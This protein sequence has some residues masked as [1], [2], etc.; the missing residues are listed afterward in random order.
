MT[1]NIGKAKKID[2]IFVF[3]KSYVTFVAS[4][5]NMKNTFFYYNTYYYFLSQGAGSL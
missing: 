2:E 4:I 3:E 1:S 5:K